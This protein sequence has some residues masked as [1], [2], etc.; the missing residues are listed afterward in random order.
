MIVEYLPVSPILM[1]G[2]V[3]TVAGLSSGLSALVNTVDGLRYFITLYSF[4]ASAI[5]ALSPA[6]L[7]VIVKKEELPHAVGQLLL[8]ATV[9]VLCG[10]PAT[11]ET[12]ALIT[13][14]YSKP[15][16]CIERKGLGDITI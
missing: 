14:M 6:T 10:P 5:N 12:Y 13:Q 9:C 15:E 1:Q 11:G 3:V 4:L 2:V 7:L 16:A 8:P